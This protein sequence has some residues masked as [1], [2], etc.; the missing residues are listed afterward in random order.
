MRTVLEEEEWEEDL[1][2]QHT[3]QQIETKIEILCLMVVVGE[4]CV[5]KI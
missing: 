1:V 2:R 5:D 4:C 3:A